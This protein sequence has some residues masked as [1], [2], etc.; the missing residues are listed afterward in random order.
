MYRY[1]RNKEMLD[2]KKNS[3]STMVGQFWPKNNE[4]LVQLVFSINLS[5]CVKLILCNSQGAVIIIV[6]TLKRKQEK[7]FLRDFQ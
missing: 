5:K 6:Q 7:I 3:E 1:N 2:D 4:N